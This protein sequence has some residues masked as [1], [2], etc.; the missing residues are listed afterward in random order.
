MI[1]L[2]EDLLPGSRRSGAEGNGSRCVVAAAFRKE[3][4]A[5]I[6]LAAVPAIPS[7]PVKGEANHRHRSG[8]SPSARERR[9]L[10]R[11]DQ[12]WRDGQACRVL[13]GRVLERLRHWEPNL[14]DALRACL[15]MPQAEIRWVE[16]R[17]S[18]HDIG[19]PIVSRS[20]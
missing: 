12:A 17:S 19:R 9:G 11:W 2:D 10:S 20:R 18:V 3:A 15:P 14:E 8:P 1:R 16:Q 5:C 4:A 7:T 13:G 6:V